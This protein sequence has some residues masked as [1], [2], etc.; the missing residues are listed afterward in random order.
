LEK[1]REVFMDGKWVTWPPFKE[2]IANPQVCPRYEECLERLK[3]KAKRLG[4]KPK[5]LPC[6][7]H[8]DQMSKRWLMGILVSNA[9]ELMREAEG[10]PTDNFKAHHNYIHPKKH[11]DETPSPAI[12]ESIKQGERAVPKENK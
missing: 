11:P 7:L 3:R 6:R 2:I 9:V 1:P 12:L 5:K 10:L 4:R 8:A